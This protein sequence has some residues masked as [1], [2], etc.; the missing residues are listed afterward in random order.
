MRLFKKPPYTKQIAIKPPEP[1]PDR[2]GVAIAA[3]VRNEGS[4]I[5]EWLAYH[6]AVGIRH[7]I[8]YD[9]GSTDETV[10]EIKRTLPADSFT[11]IP[12]SLRTV[13]VSSYQILN[14]QAIAFSHAILNFGRHYRWMAF[15]D[16]DEFLLPKSG[17]TVEEALL[18]V[19]GFPNVSLPWHMFGTS[20]HDRRPPG[21]ILE[22][23]TMRGADPLSRKKNASNFKCVVDPCEVTEVSIHHFKTRLHGENTCNDVGYVTTR[24]GR[25]SPAFYSSGALQLNHYYSKSKEEL[26]AKLA[27]GPASPASRLRYETRVR[28]AMASIESDMVEDGQMIAFLNRNGIKL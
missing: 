9:D 24:K 2:A 28:T 26:E 3:T 23:Y 20:N 5:T 12:W 21:P 1:A 10:S 25:K 27:R 14:S 11:I 7:F 8:I 15:I 19:N 17:K 16:A 13:D 6:R 22:N 18:R 4:Y